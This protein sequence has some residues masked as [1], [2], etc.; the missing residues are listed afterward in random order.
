MTLVGIQQR[1]ISLVELLVGMAIGLMTILVISQVFLASEEQRRVPTSGANTQINGILAIDALQRDIR[2]SGYGLADAS[3][4]GCVVA[5]SDS[6]RAIGLAGQSISPVLIETATS[7]T[8]SDAITVLSSNKVDASFPIKNAATHSAA[9]T[10]FVIHTAPTAAKGDWMIVAPIGSNNCAAFQVLDITNNGATST[11]AHA[12][13]TGI[14][15]VATGSSI[16]NL[17]PTPYYRRWSVNNDFQLQVGN[18]AQTSASDA[19]SEIVLM[20]AFYAKDTDGSGRVNS[21][22]TTAPT[23]AAQWSQVLGIRVAIVA[24]SPNRDKNKITTGPLEWNLG[25]IA[26]QNSKACTTNSTS[27][28]LELNLSSSSTGD[29]WEFYRYRLFDTMIPMRNLLWN[30]ST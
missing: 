4:L 7:A 17:G 13:D 28:C 29:E 3:I 30:S 14:S 1:G 21:Y 11:L 25:S 23:T 18:P 6:S 5:N 9:S 20:R 24:R 8:G 12:A 16:V 27:Q 10:D 26:A 19:Y 15:T 2:H 22:D